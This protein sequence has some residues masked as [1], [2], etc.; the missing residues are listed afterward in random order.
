MR[1]IASRGCEGGWFQARGLIR[2]R[3]GK[4]RKSAS[5]LYTT[6]PWSRSRAARITTGIGT[7]SFEQL[8]ELRGLQAAVLQGQVQQNAPCLNAEVDKMGPAAADPDREIVDG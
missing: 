7:S 2:R 4:R 6:P 8:P 5:Q 1:G 3:P